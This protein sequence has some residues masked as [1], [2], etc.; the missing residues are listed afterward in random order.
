[1]VDHEIKK[2][3]EVQEDPPAFTQIIAQSTQEV[4][5]KLHGDPIS[6]VQEDREPQSAKK[7]P[8][9]CW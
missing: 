3:S 5:Q 9:I 7:D 4:E 1:M 8:H 6:G 2:N